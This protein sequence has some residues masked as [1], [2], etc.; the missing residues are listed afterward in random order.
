MEYLKS[1]NFDEILQQLVRDAL[2]EKPTDALAFAAAWTAKKLAVRDQGKTPAAASSVDTRDTK[3]AGASPLDAPM[4][5]P[6]C[7]RGDSSKLMLDG[8]GKKT[9]VVEVKNVKECATLDVNDPLSVVSYS[10]QVKLESTDPAEVG[11]FLVDFAALVYNIFVSTH[12]SLRALFVDERTTT[13]AD[14]VAAIAHFIGLIVTRRPSTHEFCKQVMQRFSL[15]APAMSPQSAILL[16]VRERHIN[17]M[18]TSIL[19]AAEQVYTPSTWKQIGSSWLGAF[20][21]YAEELRSTVREAQAS[22][23]ELDSTPFATASRRT[24]AV[25]DELLLSPS[26][27][28]ADALDSEFEACISKASASWT[29]VKVN[30]VDAVK[31]VWLFLTPLQQERICRKFFA[32]LFTQ[33]RASVT[34]YFVDDDSDAESLVEQAPVKELQIILTQLIRGFLS[35]EG[36][37][38]LAKERAMAYTAGIEQRHLHY[39][40]SCMLTALSL[41]LGAKRMAPACSEAWRHFLTRVLDAVSEG[42][43]EAQ[44]TLSPKCSQASDAARYSS[45]LVEKGLKLKIDDDNRLEIVTQTSPFI[46]ASECWSAMAVNDGGRTRVELSEMFFNVLFTQHPALNKTLFRNAQEESAATSYLPTLVQQ[47][48]DGHLSTSDLRVIGATALTGRG[49]DE[50]KAEHVVAAAMSVCALTLGITN[51]REREEQLR[52]VVHFIAYNLVHGAQNSA[53]VLAAR[54]PDVI[55]AESWTTMTNKE[56]AIRKAIDVLRIQHRALTNAVLEGIDEQSFFPQA[57]VAVTAA[58]TST[59]Q[60]EDAKE[61]L[62]KLKARSGGRPIEKKHITYICMAV[63][64]AVGILLGSRYQNMPLAAHWTKQVERIST[65]VIS[66]L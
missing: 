25:N 5:P 61:L 27:A 15:F 6:G 23:A 36:V 1:I 39:A 11:T 31:G 12:P 48:L 57:A 17:Y 22:I 53:A 63:Q 13:E 3:C 66:L 7:P 26:P 52:E 42:V 20:G 43:D 16:R 29:F 65:F 38:K 47:V 55:V 41:E 49:L 60:P 64:S 56:A 8:S 51:F 10:W 58:L 28:L 32:V 9:T 30:P 14:V 24:S 21:A 46:I 2:D 34:R 35:L 50:Q 33:H 62:S 44:G 40:L 37:Q 59:L 54:A 45:E 18:L 4:S 19:Y